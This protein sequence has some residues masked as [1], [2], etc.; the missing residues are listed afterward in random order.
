MYIFEPIND[1]IVCTW[2]NKDYV[3]VDYDNKTYIARSRIESRPYWYNEDEVHVSGVIRPYTSEFVTE[4]I[5][6]KPD[7]SIYLCFKIND[8]TYVGLEYEDYEWWFR[9]IR[10][11]KRGYK[12][13]LNESDWINFE[14][15]KSSGTESIEFKLFINS[16]IKDTI[17]IDFDPNTKFRLELKNIECKWLKAV[18]DKYPKRRNSLFW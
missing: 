11:F 4:S 15:H 6:L 1:Q 2:T 7:E 18:S 8:W 17:N 13:P 5:F 14:L 10:P 3:K 12:K 9:V 16:E